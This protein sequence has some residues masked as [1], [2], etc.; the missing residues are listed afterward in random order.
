MRTSLFAVLALVAAGCG[1]VCDGIAAAENGANQKA[2][3]CNL[4]NITVHDANKCDVGLQSKCSAD[5]VS[6]LKNYAACLNGLPVCTADNSV[7]FAFS[8]GGCQTQVLSK[9]S[10]TCLGAIQ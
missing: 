2:L 4:T 6:G 5:D 9:V 8:R 10:L 1:T 3:N 7:S